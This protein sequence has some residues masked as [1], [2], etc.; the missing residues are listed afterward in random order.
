MLGDRQE[1]T[2]GGPT[3][4]ECARRPLECL[5]TVRAWRRERVSAVNH[6]TE[7][8]V[9]E[10]VRIRSPQLRRHVNRLDGDS[11]RVA[12]ADSVQKGT[13]WTRGTYRATG[14]RT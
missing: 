4:R 5:P 12:F 11:D 7:E 8:D 2:R 10:L 14:I 3:R 13:R 9:L 6:T 1:R